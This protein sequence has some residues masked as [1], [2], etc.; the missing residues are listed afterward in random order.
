MHS[1][2]NASFKP[3]AEVTHLC[4][5]MDIPVENCQFGLVNYNPSHAESHDHV[6]QMLITTAPRTHQ[7]TTAQSTPFENND[8]IN[9][10]AMLLQDGALATPS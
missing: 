9:Y 1:F 8:S 2:S 4:K 5:I 6:P 3:A 7:S 10:R